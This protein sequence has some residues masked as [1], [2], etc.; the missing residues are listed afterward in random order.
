MAAIIKPDIAQRVSHSKIWALMA[1]E[2]IDGSNPNIDDVKGQLVIKEDPIGAIDVF[3]T[4]R[5][6]TDETEERMSSE[7]LAPVI[8]KVNPDGRLG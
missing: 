1:D 6:L 4:L 5:Q 3:A 8:K 7:S 2:T